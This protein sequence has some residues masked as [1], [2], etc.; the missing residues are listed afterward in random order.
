M[1]PDRNKMNR[2]IFLIPNFCAH[3]CILAD[4]NIVVI[5]AKAVQSSGEW[6]NGWVP[7][8]MHSIIT[9]PAQTSIAGVCEGCFS[10]TSG[11]R[12]PGVPALGAVCSGLKVH[13][14]QTF[15]LAKQ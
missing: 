14:E 11:A 5:S 4:P 12:N 7:L 2:N 3:C 8:R 9:P 10:K 1:F 15:G 6:K 13:N